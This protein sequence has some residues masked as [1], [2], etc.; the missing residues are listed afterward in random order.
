MKIVY[1]ANARIPT[2]KAHGIQIMKTCEAFSKLGHDV[3]LVVPRRLNH[4]KEDPFSY[5]STSTKFPIKRLPCLDLVELGF[6]GFLIQS[7]TFGIST[8]FYLRRKDFDILY[9]REEFSLYFESFMDTP[10]VWET[11]TDRY[12]FIIKRV[13]RKAKKIVSITKGLKQFYVDQGIPPKKIA[14]SPDAVDIED[15]TISVD[16]EVARKEFNLPLRP[17]LIMYAGRLDTWKGYDTL[18]ESAKLFQNDSTKLVIVGGEEKQVRKLKNK[19]KDVLFLGYIPYIKL[20]RFQKAADVLVVPNTAKVDISRYHTSPLKV[21]AHMTSGIPIVASDLPS[22]REILNEKNSIL[23]KPDSKDE[24]A[25]GIM[26]VLNDPKWAKELAKQAKIDV[27]Q[28]SWEKRAKNIIE[29]I[30]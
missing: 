25:K 19:Y 8:F 9:G 2:E 4:I 12:N 13:L 14:V 11:H 7:I 24:L 20:P 22:I 18:L 3:E 29:A 21:F 26:S 1:L 6:V 16:R 27:M 10:F 28:Y 30:S 23:V 17:R 15:F 5:Y